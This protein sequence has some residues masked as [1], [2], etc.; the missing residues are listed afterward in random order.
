MFSKQLTLE[1]TTHKLDGQL[2]Q[3]MNNFTI[4]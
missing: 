1:V 3:F 4:L 2:K